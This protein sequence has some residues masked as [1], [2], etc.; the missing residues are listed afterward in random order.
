[1]D[2]RAPVGTDQ[3]AVVKH[4]VSVFR[5]LAKKVMKK[6]SMTQNLNFR[7]QLEGGIRYFDLRVSSKPGDPDHEVYFIHG[8][9]GLRVRDGLNDINN[10]LNF[11]LKEIVFL[12]F[13]HHYAMDHEH[14]RYL[15]DMLKEVF[16][17]KLCRINVVE[18]IT[19]DY[20]WKKKYQVLFQYSTDIKLTSISFVTYLPTYLSCLPT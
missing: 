3:K 10:F 7:E 18:D 1:M 13:N 4:L 5:L 20:L 2:E 6:W 9:F 19:L 8:L 12:D 11:H 14:H 15:I 17:S 16:G